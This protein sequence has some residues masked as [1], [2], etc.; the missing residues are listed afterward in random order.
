[1]YDRMEPVVRRAIDAYEYE[2]MFDR[3]PKVDDLLC[4]TLSHGGRRALKRTRKAMTNFTVE[5]AQK[6]F[7]DWTDLERMLTVKFIDGNVKAQNPDG[8]FLHTEY[9]EG[10]PEG[11]EQPGYTSFW[12]QAVAWFHGKV[13]EIK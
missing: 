1:M 12:K 4:R 7:S 2:M 11:L 9:D 13:V 10:I 3:V 5:S 8:T 6:Q